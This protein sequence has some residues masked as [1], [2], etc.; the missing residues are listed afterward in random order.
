MAAQALPG[1]VTVLDCTR[2]Y[3]LTVPRI[4]RKRPP[5]VL[6]IPPTVLYSCTIGCDR[7]TVSGHGE[8]RMRTPFL[9]RLCAI[10]VGIKTLIWCFLDRSTYAASTAPPPAS[11]SPR[12]CT[13]HLGCPRTPGSPRTR[14]GVAAVW[15]REGTL[16]GHISA[17]TARRRRARGWCALQR[18]AD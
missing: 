17:D 5:A 10:P 8:M 3:V 15:T 4:D 1:M 6:G 14:L 18:A 7:G 16:R 2:T 11:A 12:P 9:D 13:R